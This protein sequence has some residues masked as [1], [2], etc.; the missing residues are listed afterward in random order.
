MRATLDDL[1]EMSEATLTFLRAKTAAED[2]RRIDLAALVDAVCEDYRAGERAVV[3]EPGAR[4]IVTCRPSAIRR[5]LRNVID[6]ALA[7]G[8]VA[9]IGLTTQ[10][11]QAVIEIADRGPGIAVADREQV[12]DAFVRLEASRSRQTGGAGLGLA[13]ARS[14]IRGHGGEITLAERD[15]GG[16]RVRMQLPLG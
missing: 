13:I 12:F 6:N 8:Q 7:Y 10:A 15:G 2:T 5:A 1:A 14:V 11:G 4:V 3:F 16:L 9:D